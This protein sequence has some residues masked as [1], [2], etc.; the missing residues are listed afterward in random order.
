MSGSFNQSQN[1][2]KQE[3]VTQ[4]INQNTINNFIIQNPEKVEVIEYAPEK[5]QPIPEIKPTT[6]ISVHEHNANNIIKAE[7]MVKKVVVPQKKVIFIILY[8]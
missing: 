5:A 1:E 8:I 2:R 3:T 7:V 6:L 4:I